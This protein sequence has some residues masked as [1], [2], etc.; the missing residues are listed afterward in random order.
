[1]EGE[2]AGRVSNGKVFCMAAIAL[3]GFGTYELLE[4]S[5]NAWGIGMLILI[6]LGA[7][8]IYLIEG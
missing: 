1:M 7:C 5:T 4:W 2:R 6:S 8:V 3:L